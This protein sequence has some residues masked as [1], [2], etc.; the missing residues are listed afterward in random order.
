MSHDHHQSVYSAYYVVCRFIHGRCATQRD[1]HEFGSSEV[2]LY[3]KHQEA[4]LKDRVMLH[5]R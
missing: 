2:V 3:N 1:V 5:D 4:F